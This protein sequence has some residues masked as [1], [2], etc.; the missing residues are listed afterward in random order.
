MRDIIGL[1][2]TPAGGVLDVA[3]E[4][5]PLDTAFMIT[6]DVAAGWHLDIRHAF[7][8][9][10]PTAD[11]EHMVYGCVA[12]ECG[13]HNAYGMDVARTLGMAPHEFHGDVYVLT[14]NTSSR[15]NDPGFDG[16]MFDVMPQ[17]ERDAIRAQV[18]R[19]AS[20]VD[21]ARV[22]APAGA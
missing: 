12:H 16:G 21:A 9:A 2:I 3:G 20:I 19:M 10:W 6:A 7:D 17:T 5:D 14:L 4:S 1:K 22:G 18:A 8:Y 15:L 13:E 11:D